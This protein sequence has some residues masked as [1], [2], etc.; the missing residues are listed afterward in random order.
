MPPKRKRNGVS[1][2]FVRRLWNCDA[3]RPHQGLDESDLLIRSRL[4][5]VIVEQCKDTR[6]TA[7]QRKKADW[8]SWVGEHEQ[9]L[10]LMLGCVARNPGATINKIR[11]Q[12]R[13]KTSLSSR[14]GCNYDVTYI[15][16]ISW[17]TPY[18]KGIYSILVNVSPALRVDVQLDGMT[19]PWCPLV[20]VSFSMALRRLD[21]RIE[22]K[23]VA[24]D[25]C[26]DE[27]A[28]S[29]ASNEDPAWHGP[30]R[31]HVMIWPRSY[32]AVKLTGPCC[33]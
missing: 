5:S 10:Q 9:Q 21:S 23:V 11:E 26:N 33:P 15:W 28:H 18:G 32:N 7:A 30:V 8:G 29:V 14:I 3:P 1:R 17:F 12:I 16:D 31:Q 20:H 24:L 4:M 22:K 13:S 2:I 25:S 19:T 27:H 6:V